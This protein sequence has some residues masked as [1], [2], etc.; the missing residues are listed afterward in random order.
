MLADPDTM[1]YNRAWGGTI[2]FEEAQWKEWYDHWIVFPEGKRFY[3]YVTDEGGSFA[4]EAAYHYDS[5]SG[6]YL[7]DVIIYAPFRN[8]GHGGKALDLLAEAAAKNGIDC[9]YDN[10]ASDNPARSMFLKHGFREEYRT[11]EIVML[12]RDLKKAR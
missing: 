10:I 1:S 9:L 8:R 2:A 3:R 5:G 7:A 12:K 4:G 6:L 11:D